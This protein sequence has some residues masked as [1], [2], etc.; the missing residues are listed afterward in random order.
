VTFASRADVERYLA[1]VFLGPLTDRP[2]AE[3]PALAAE[4]VS[5]LPSP[6]LDYVRLNL[7][8]TRA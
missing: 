7:V 5:R 1:T 6:L 8:A 4:L 3:L 2:A